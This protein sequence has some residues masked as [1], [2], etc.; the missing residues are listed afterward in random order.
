MT[1]GQGNTWWI[2][3]SNGTLIIRSLISVH[4]GRWLLQQGTTIGMCSSSDESLSCARYVI[5]LVACNETWTLTE[6]I[7]SP[8]HATHLRSRLDPRIYLHLKIAKAAIK[9]L[10]VVEKVK[11]VRWY[12]QTGQQ[13][14]Y[15]FRTAIGTSSRWSVAR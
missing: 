6:R 2:R 11:R 12:N 10:S 9:Y 15:R 5:P 3:F 1:Y 7:Y 8:K 4:M 14:I 13:L